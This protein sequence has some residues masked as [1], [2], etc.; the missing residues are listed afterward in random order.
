MN[1]ALSCFRWAFVVLPHVP[2]YAILSLFRPSQFLVIIVLCFIYPL[3]IV[4]LFPVVLRS[5]F[6]WNLLPTT[7]INFSRICSRRDR[8]M[9]ARAL[10][11]LA[12]VL[13][14]LC[15]GSHLHSVQ[16]I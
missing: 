6:H 4:S 5:I 14:E 13:F 11:I 2:S 7:L 9:L 3:C 8:R 16:Y 12:S 1:F 10:S 15:I